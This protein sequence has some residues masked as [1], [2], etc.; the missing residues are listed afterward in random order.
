M[1]TYYGK[2]DDK[3]VIEGI[4]ATRFTWYAKREGKGIRILIHKIINILNGIADFLHW[5]ESGYKLCCIFAYIRKQKYH[6]KGIQHALC[7]KCFKQRIE[8]KND[9]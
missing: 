8:K 4:Q 1:T 2:I 6:I 5:L 9:G 3:I 7:Y